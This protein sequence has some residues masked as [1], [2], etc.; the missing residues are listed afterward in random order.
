MTLHGGMKIHIQ[1]IMNAV[2]G[3]QMESV[4]NPITSKV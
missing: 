2:L 4:M 1:E 3:M